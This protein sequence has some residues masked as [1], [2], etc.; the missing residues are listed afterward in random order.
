MIP[1]VE[2]ASLSDA[3]RMVMTPR[4]SPKG[5]SVSPLPG[6]LS[7]LEEAL[8][9]ALKQITKRRKRVRCKIGT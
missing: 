4:Q 9:Q 7:I 8:L 1:T 5:R 3:S 6:P 2:I